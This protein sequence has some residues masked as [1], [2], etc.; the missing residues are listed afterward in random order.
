MADTI[1]FAD[2]PTLTGEL[3]VLRPLTD[4]DV[5]AVMSALT[6]SES[7]RLT[8]THRRFTVEQVA[9]ALREWSTRDDRID[10]AVI[11]RATGRHAGEV[12]LNELD[13][14]NLSCNFRIALTTD[15][16]NRG[17]GTEA[18]RLILR[19]AFDTVGVHR[20][21]L[22]VY[23]FNP[24]ARRVYEKVGFVYEGTRRHALRWNGEW[25]DAYIMAMLADD[26][27]AHRILSSGRP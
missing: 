22:D 4:A 5:P 26:W 27:A 1:S 18:T 3:V 25:V 13:G 23:S 19:H 16:T 11:D 12:V 10:L 20:V 9:T 14:D 8:G 15:H 6:D 17:L 7:M 21:E 24:R 2:K